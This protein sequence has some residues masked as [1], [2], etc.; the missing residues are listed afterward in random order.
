MNLLSYY[1]K[2]YLG[3]ICTIDKYNRYIIRKF[4]FQILIAKK[5]K[6]QFCIRGHFY[7]T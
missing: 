3:K 5:F 4:K 1:A 7:I 6:F 2:Q